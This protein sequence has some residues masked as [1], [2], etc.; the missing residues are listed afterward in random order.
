[1]SDVVNVACRCGTPLVVLP[2]AVLEAVSGEAELA[3]RE[4]TAE[5]QD[6]EGRRFTIAD[7]QGAFR[8]PVCWARR[9]LSELPSG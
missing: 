7:K 5:L 3:I 6:E 1:V 4:N 8:C 9:T 2:P